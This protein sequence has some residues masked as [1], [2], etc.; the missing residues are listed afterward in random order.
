MRL[1]RFVTAAGLAARRKASLLVRQGKVAVNG[2]V[3]RDPVAEIDAAHDDVRVEGKRAII[4][5]KATVLL[6]KP[7]G[8]VTT[9]DDPEG[10]QTVI[11]LVRGVGARVVPVGRLDYHTEGVLLLTNDGELANT[12]LHPSRRVER[13]YHAKLKGTLARE[14]LEKLRRGVRL[15]DGVA[16]A[17]RVKV[18][19]STGK[20]TWVELALHEGRNRQIH[21]MALAIRHPVLKLARVS[22]AGLGVGDLRPGEWRYLTRAEIDRLRL[23][24][25]PPGAPDPDARSRDR[26]AGRWSRAGRGGSQA[27]PG[28]RSDHR[29]RR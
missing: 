24:V 15:E 13:V 19:A 5:D 26:A 6:C 3:V 25:T 8:V 1:Q 18:L 29:A 9:L 27:R 12:L 20:H 11:D 22:F 2:H 17:D 21:R 14:D 28:S 16:R 10:R 7:R 4:Q 23:A